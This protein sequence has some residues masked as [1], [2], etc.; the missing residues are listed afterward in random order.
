MTEAANSLASRAVANQDLRPDVDPMNFL[1]AV[2]GVSYAGS[3]T[4]W[5]ETARQIVDILI[6]GSRPYG[7]S[8][9][10][11]RRGVSRLISAACLG[12][13]DAFHAQSSSR[14]RSDMEERYRIAAATNV[15]RPGELHAQCL[16]IRSIRE[17]PCMHWE[18]MAGDHAR[19]VGR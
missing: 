2:H 18:Y 6:Q 4:D 9:L 7:G 11:A 12:L 17:R 14:C 15:L 1:R 10:F 19:L 3:S 5:P 13:G 8:L 16:S